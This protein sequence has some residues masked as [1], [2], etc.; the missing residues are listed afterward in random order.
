VLRTA[1]DLFA[2][3]TF[4]AVSMDDIAAAAGIATS[5]LYHYFPGK[6]DL[7]SIALERGNGYLQLS[8]DRTLDEVSDEAE[9]L[10]QLTTSYCRFAFAHP[11][12]VD[13]LITES[14]TL[15]LDRGRALTESERD[16]LAEWVHLYRALDPQRD[17][18]EATVVVQ[19]TLMLVNDLARLSD[20]R[21]RPNAEAYVADLAT[22]ALLGSSGS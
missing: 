7:L 2:A 3:N 13:L 20:L 11:A 15:P 21:T 18:A 10:R 12:V 14:R 19:G 1:L 4:A 6:A 9:A 17:Q 16:Y 5:T 22:G 8:L